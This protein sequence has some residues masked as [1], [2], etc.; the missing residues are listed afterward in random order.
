SVGRE[1][2][3]QALETMHWHKTGAL[4]EAS[5]QLGA[6][7]SGKAD[8]ASLR[9]LQQYARAVGLAFQ[10]QD[11]I[12]DVESDTATLGKTQGK[13]EANHKPTYPALL[14][15]EQAKAYALGRR[16]QAL[17]ALRPFGD[18]AEPLRELARDVVER[19]S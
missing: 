3:Q 15:L 13:D 16:D 18:R 4:I 19:R 9:S 2:D 17:H 11:D 1:L 7:A 5:V 12:L 14:G 6:L 8:V 10:V